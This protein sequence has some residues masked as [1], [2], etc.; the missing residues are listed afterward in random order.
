MKAQFSFTGG[1]SSG[2]EFSY[3][4]GGKTINFFRPSGTGGDPNDAGGH[5]AV[6]LLVVMS[7]FFYTQNFFKKILLVIVLLMSIAALILTFSRGSWVSF[8]VGLVVFFFMALRHHWISGKRIVAP[9]VLMSIVLGVFSLPITA[10]LS[11]DDGGSAYSRVPLIKLA[12]EMIL[13]HPFIGVGANN[14]G[15]VIPQYLSS[16][17][18]GQWLHIVHSQYL[19]IFAETGLIGMVF[20]LVILGNMIF[21]CLRCIRAKDPILSPISIGVISGLIA[22]FL[23]MGVELS[24]SRL[25]VQLFWIMVSITIASER[26]IKNNRRPVLNVPTP[27]EVGL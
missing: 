1:F 17:L 3:F 25:T 16:E 8:A 2:F 15:M 26:L 6:L 4:H 22:L 24:I 12:L 23:H 5:I 18:R 20:F 11:Q 27:M 7:L 9:A 14:F 13:N 21:I 10:R 19:L